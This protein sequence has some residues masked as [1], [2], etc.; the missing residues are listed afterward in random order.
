MIARALFVAL[1]I[2][3]LTA[4]PLGARLGTMRAK[5]SWGMRTGLERT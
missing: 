2:R 3:S 5:A 1:L 4:T